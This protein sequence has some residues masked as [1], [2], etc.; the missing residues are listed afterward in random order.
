MQGEARIRIPH[1][2]TKR[3]AWVR[4]APPQPAKEVIVLTCGGRLPLLFNL[5]WRSQIPSP[6][7]VAAKARGIHL[8]VGHARLHLG[9]T[10][11]RRARS[12]GAS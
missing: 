10:A 8:A 4:I 11:T 7:R 9:M 2:R 3:K 6:E 5:L 1:G 12:P